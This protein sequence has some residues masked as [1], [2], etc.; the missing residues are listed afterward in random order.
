MRATG[1]V[2]FFAPG[3]P[4][5]PG[6]GTIRDQLLHEH[7]PITACF[8]KARPYQRVTIPLDNELNKPVEVKLY[9]KSDTSDSFWHLLETKA[10][11]A[12]IVGTPTQD[13]ITLTDWW[14]HLKMTVQVT[15][16]ADPTLGDFR[17][18]ALPV[19]HEG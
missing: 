4:A 3:D 5:T 19:V 2:T 1:P 10:L 11:V 12:G 8:S 15:G 16:G 17:S 6:G 14:W 7:M 18:E 9:G 13:V